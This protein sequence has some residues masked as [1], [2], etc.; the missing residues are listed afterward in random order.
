MGFRA[1]LEERLL[2]RRRIDGGCWIWTGSVKP[3]GYGQIA[4]GPPLNRVLYVHRAAWMLWRGEI[5]AGHVLH[6]QCGN[7]ACFNP[8]HL[9]PMTKETHTRLHDWDRIAWRFRPTEGGGSR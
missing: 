5:P 4:E 6:H 7:K 1:P 3:G 8:D 9:E 2:R